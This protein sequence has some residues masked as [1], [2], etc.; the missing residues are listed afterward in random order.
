MNAAK[1]NPCMGYKDNLFNLM[2]LQQGLPLGGGCAGHGC[3]AAFNFVALLP[4]GEVHACRKMPSLIGNIYKEK[5]SDIYFSL[6][7]Q[8][9]RAGSKSCSN[10]SIR[11]VCGGCPAV[12][13]GLGKDIYTDRDPYCFKNQE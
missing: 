13:Y 9:Y 12:S 11:P 4:D 10:C 3:G 8:K 6:S 1:S 7:A 5:L 2:R